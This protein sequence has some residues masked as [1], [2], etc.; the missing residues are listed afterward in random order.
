MTNNL[1]KTLQEA[2]GFDPL[3]KV[4]PNTQDADR[5]KLNK[6]GLLAQAIIPAVLVGFY[7]YSRDEKNAANIINRNAS[8]DW[9]RLIFGSSRE[10][11]ANIADYAGIPVG[12]AEREIG[13]LS[14]LAA[15][16]IRENVG[17]GADGKKVKEYLTLQRNDILHYLPA[18]LQL[19]DML[20]DNTLD[21]RTN[22]MEGPVSNA[23]HKIEQIFAGSDNVEG[24]DKKF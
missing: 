15:D 5:S 19:G 1:V 12:E 24:K 17:P 11:R 2:A 3:Q 10:L 22:K 9:P 23:M 14:E 4:D 16:K 6:P 13:I 18:A 21:D 8:G 20:N 7:K